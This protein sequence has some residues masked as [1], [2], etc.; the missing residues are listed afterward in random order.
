MK[1]ELGCWFYGILLCIAFAIIY[2]IIEKIAGSPAE[3]SFKGLLLPLISL[4]IFI[5]ILSLAGVI[6]KK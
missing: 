5:S 1:K 6:K 4:C 3:S 2:T